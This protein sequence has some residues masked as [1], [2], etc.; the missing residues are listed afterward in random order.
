MKKFILPFV[1]FKP[2][3]NKCDQITVRNLN[4]SVIINDI[5][6]NTK[7]F[8]NISFHSSIHNSDTIIITTKNSFIHKILYFDNK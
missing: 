3:I 4:N 8:K 7:I 6:K 2:I 5:F 1:K